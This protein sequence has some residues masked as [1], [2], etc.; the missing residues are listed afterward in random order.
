M[1]GRGDSLR[2]RAVT[3]AAPE[4]GNVVA[5]AGGV[6]NRSPRIAG[7]AVSALTVAVMGTDIALRVVLPEARGSVDGLSLLPLVL[8]LAAVGGLIIAR[9]SGHPYGWVLAVVALTWSCRSLAI[10]YAA[11]ADTR[12]YAGARAATVVAVAADAIAWGTFVTFV[13][14]LYPTGELPSPR[15]RWVGW[16]AGV[17]VT[18]MAVGLSMT[19]ATADLS[20]VLRAFS[21]GTT[22]PERG[23]AA[24]INGTGH[25]GIFFGMIAGVVGLFVR[26]RRADAIERLQ[27]KWFL[28][29]AAITAVSI[30]VQ[31]FPA[32]DAVSWLEVVSLT[33]M[34][35][36]IGIAILRWHL[37]E[38]DRIISR[39]LGY[40]VLT[41]LLAGVYLGSVTLITTLTTPLAPDSPVAVAIATLA[42]A[43]AFQPVRRRIQ[44][45][46]DRRFNRARYDAQRTAEGYRAR[47]RDQL[48]LDTIADDLIAA[49][50]PSLQP[51][52]ALVWIAP[53]VGRSELVTAV[54]STV[55]PAAAALWSR[56]SS[57]GGFG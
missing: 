3:N 21:Q 37:Y 2:A 35:I 41:V 45:A 31:F 54:R 47:L 10:D 36:V 42:V 55:Q 50:H 25:A 8:A 49:V 52:A 1:T 24:V 6:I 13:L 51:Q 46:V 22:A 26:A 27:L 9:K 19:A 33:A 43:G 14:L 38:I 17:G 28:L 23:V 30:L 18:A 16:V 57:D 39:T 56:E 5:A 12:S 44:S 48:D 40:V 15:W 4:H 53:P 11:L 7:T 29:G 34:P 32:A 20:A